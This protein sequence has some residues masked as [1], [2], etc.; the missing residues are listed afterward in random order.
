MCQIFKTEQPLTTERPSSE[1]VSV[2]FGLAL[3]S[4]WGCLYWSI[5]L[6]E[7]D[8]LS[9]VCETP[10]LYCETPPVA[11]SAACQTFAT[12]QAICSVDI[13]KDFTPMAAFVAFPTSFIQCE[14]VQ[15]IYFSKKK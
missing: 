10:V 9:Y 4:L 7:C 13:S 2:F 5:H 11:L 14:K 6:V 15:C 3:V 8:L 12:S 1:A